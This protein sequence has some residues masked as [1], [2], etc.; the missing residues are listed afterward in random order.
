M[1]DCN[2]TV[3]GMD[4]GHVGF[5]S[6]FT[7][8]LPE[9]HEG[10]HDYGFLPHATSEPDV[11]PKQTRHWSIEQDAEENVFDVFE[12]R[13]GAAYA[14]PLQDAVAFVRNHRRYAKGDRV[15]VLDRQGRPMSLLS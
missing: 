1:S 7:C 12:D 14:L 4:C 8:R 15:T 13:R 9:G 6:R 2:S 11:D 3:V 10:V 5:S